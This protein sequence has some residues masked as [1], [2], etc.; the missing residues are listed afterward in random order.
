[1][2]RYV[3]SAGIQPGRRGGST[4][5][6]DAERETLSMLRA[7][8]EKKDQESTGNKMKKIQL[9]DHFTPWKILVFSLPSIGMQIVDNTYQVADGYFIS[10]YI[11]ETAFSAENLIYPPLLIFMY[12]G[13]MFGTGASALI[14]KELGEGRKEK[15]NQLLSMTMAALGTF[16]VVVSIALYFLVPSLAVWV[17]ATPELVPDCVR[18][19]RLLACFMP[20]QMFSMAFHPLLI[21]AERSG[22]GLWTTIANAAANILLDWLFIAEFGWGM[23]GVA[24]ATGLA[25]VISATI[26]FVYFLKTRKGLRFARPCF[27]VP[28]LGQTLYNGASEMVDAVSYA[29]VA[30]LFNLQ[31]MRYL[32]A[33]GVAASA[34]TE[35]VAGMASSFF[36]GI[37]MSIVPVVGYQLGRKD[38]RELHGLR[39]DGMLLMG[40]FGLLMTVVCM[41]LA[42]PI[43]AIF[44]GYN[45]ELTAL[46]TEALRLVSLSFLL[47]GIT[48]YASSFFTGLNQGAASLTIAAVK[49]FAG[50]LAL[51]YLLPAI[52]GATGLWLSTAGAEILALGAA[53]GCFI[54]WKR[55]GEEKA[56]REVGKEAEA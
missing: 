20:F 26:P 34:V 29:V 54:W 1:M 50:P 13:L 41:T 2:V 48:V 56:L 9:S 45:A 46:A 31:L 49:G 11:G 7:Y 3:G 38:V 18:Y 19:G 23:E 17:G 43:S 44:V 14:S 42:T 33:D 39:R 47:S 5:R 6:R 15:A 12:I 55:S 28:A 27:D 10:N 36:Y 30:M 52:M 37:S 16:G 51:L 40:G 22:L 8:R 21:T 35:Y 24:I 53:I 4:E 32:G 25:W